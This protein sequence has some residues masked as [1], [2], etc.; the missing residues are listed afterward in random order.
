MTREAPEWLA[1]FQ[2]RFGDVI[3]TP[4]DRT[5]GTLT[6]A[7]SSYDPRVVADALD[8]SAVAGADRLAVYNRQYWLRLFDVL[9]S[10]FPLTSR[11]VGY[12]RFNDYAA[13]F[14][15]ETPPRGWDIDD[16]AD[17]FEAFFEKRLGCRDAGERRALVES[18]R[19]DAAWRHVFRAPKTHPFRPS[20]ADA[21]RLLDSRLVLSPGVAIVEETF[22]LLELRKEV[23]ADRSEKRMA[24][25]PALPSSR[26][27]A[28]VRKDDGILQVPL[29]PR[30]AELF[31]LLGN[32]SVREALAR[33]ERMCCAEERARLPANA[34]AW[35]ARSVERDFWI[36]IDPVA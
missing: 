19:L 26:A 6:V 20:A 30:E 8:G 17:G 2:R 34:Q 32:F 14:I 7:S 21:A 3:R 36:G 16:A 24:I 27:W 35:L 29:E 31:A 28:L 13:R 12:W 5:T 11:L 1:E 18:A 10:A 4:L 15:F 22:P 33:L 25:P 23:L 9:Q